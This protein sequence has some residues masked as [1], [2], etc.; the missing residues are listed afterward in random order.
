MDPILRSEGGVW[1]GWSGSKEKDPPE[2]LELLQREQSCLAVDLPADVAEK[3]YEGYANQA[4]WPLFHSFTSRLKFDPDSWQAYIEA[5]QRFC[6]AVVEQFQDGDR[7]WVHDYHLMLLPGMLRQKLPHAAI[8]F[9]LH[10]PFPA[11]DI[12]SILPR[13]EELLEGL[14]G[15]DFAA[16]HTHVHVQH[17]RRSLRRLLGIESAVDRVPHGGG[18]LRLQALP[19]GIAPDDF[20]GQLHTPEAEEQFQRLMS[21]FQDKKLI[22]AVDRLDYTKGLPERL[23]TYQRLLQSTPD[24][25]GKVV[26]LQVAVPSRENIESYQE[27]T[28]EVHE[29]ITRINGKFGTTDWA[30]VVYLH[31]G[32]SRAELVALYRAADVAWVAPLR[33]GMN[34]VAK[35]FVACKPEGDGVLVLSAFAGAAAEMG[36]ALLV[37]PLDEERTA[38]AVTRALDMHDAEK[39]E[40]MEALHERVIRNNVFVW[41]ERFLAGLDE[42]VRNRVDRAGQRPQPLDTNAL[43]RSYQDAKQR[44]LFLD[45]DGTL[46]SLVARPEH[47]VP[48]DR[49]RGLLTALASD[50]ANQVF[51]LSG[52]RASDLE[53]WLGGIPRL[54]LAAE[55]GAICRQPER[56]W[57]G[58]S[59]EPEWKQT[60]RPIL[61]HFVERIPGSFI[62]EKE[63]ALVWHFRTA[64][65][66]FGDWVAME[67][68][69]MLD[70]MLAE[71]ELRA[72]QGSKI[73]EVKPMWA[74]KGSFV[75]DILSGDD[76][77]AFVLAIGDDRTDEDMFSELPETA[78]TV[79]VGDGTSKARYYTPNTSAVLD[80]LERL[81]AGA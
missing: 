42:A 59:A 77:A 66:E 58:R 9:F 10:I 81:V 11:S 61:E 76:G 78:W 25:V 2:A 75:R 26:L 55:H 74:N 37:N 47:A 65:S 68:V 29:L 38:A 5:N 30:P 70:G 60:V 21:Q 4:L 41:G 40:R 64:E 23:R 27:L 50:T 8:G 69:T 56:G 15:A 57:E 7:I 6:A 34:L 45:Y 13:G 3:F 31:R 49:L 19:I 54:G 53:Q 73:V 18:E 79:H 22:V 67:L 48:S 80:L 17:F 28:S 51:V 63:F 44:T 24:L 43:V 35:E 1:I 39:R 12:F 72:Y 46:T 52:R 32:I 14:L 33:D 20:L 71:T 16:F 62:E 36:E